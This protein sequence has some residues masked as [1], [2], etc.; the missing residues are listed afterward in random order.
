MFVLWN[1][2]KIEICT[3]CEVCIIYTIMIILFTEYVHV[4]LYRC[5]NTCMESWLISISVEQ[6][7]LHVGQQSQQWKQISL[8]DFY[9][10]WQFW[11]TPVHVYMYMLLFSG[12]CIQ[13][14]EWTRDIK[15]HFLWFTVWFQGYW[16]SWLSSIFTNMIVTIYVCHRGH[17]LETITASICINILMNVNNYI[18]ISI[19][20]KGLLIPKRL[21]YM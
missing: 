14:Y 17:S 3:Q 2:A 7:C 9:L 16:F 19:W 1:S 4:Q 13:W 21:W 5:T 6:W 20:S 15:F 12:L 8:E 10:L 11:L 18:A